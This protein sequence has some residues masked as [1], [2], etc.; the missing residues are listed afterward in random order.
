MGMQKLAEGPSGSGMI[1]KLAE[2]PSGSGMIQK[3]AEGPSGSG[4]I[5]KLAEGPSGSGSGFKRH[6]AQEERSLAQKREI[7]ER[8]NNRINDLLMKRRNEPGAG[9]KKRSPAQEKWN[10]K[11]ADLMQRR[12]ENEAGDKKSGQDERMLKEKRTPAQKRLNKKMADL[13]QRRNEM[14]L[15]NNSE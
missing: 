8:L 15:K 3:L 13:M 1:R 14:K 2:G 11:F 6:L 7:K 10:K 12:N 5:Q 4:M 9:N